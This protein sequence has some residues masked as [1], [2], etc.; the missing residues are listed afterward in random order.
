MFRVHELRDWKR[1]LN[2]I[3]ILPILPIFATKNRP[4]YRKTAFKT[5]LNAV[6]GTGYQDFKLLLCGLDQFNGINEHHA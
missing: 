4:V 5:N 1:I 3:C 2:S 6:L